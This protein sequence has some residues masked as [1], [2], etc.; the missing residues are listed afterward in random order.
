MRPGPT[1]LIFA[2]LC[3]VWPR[4]ADADETPSAHGAD[5]EDMS[6]ETSYPPAVVYGGLCL[7]VALGAGLALRRRA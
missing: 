3:L 4:Q 1:W 7:V 2:L 6:E 5:S